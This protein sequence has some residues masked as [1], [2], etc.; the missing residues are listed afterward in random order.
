M[1]KEKIK[2]IVENVDETPNKLLLE[3]R[4]TLITEFTE[5]K[6]LIVNLTRHLDAI[7]LI[8]NKINNELTNRLK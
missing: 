6:E 4:D 1:N 8:Y 7:E 5:T 2:E 3:A